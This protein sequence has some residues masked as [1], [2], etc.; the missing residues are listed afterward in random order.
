MDMI[1][2]TSGNVRRGRRIMAGEGMVTPRQP[3]AVE[4]D[5][6]VE[7]LMPG[8]DRLTVEH[9]LVRRQPEKFDLC[10]KRDRATRMRLREY[11]ER[12]LR[13]I[14]RELGERP[15]DTASCLR[16]PTSAANN[17]GLGVSR[18]RPKSWEL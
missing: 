7:T 2:T 4:E 11:H 5:G 3:M 16:L 10:W 8:R 15:T 13:H 14:E 9:P 17:Y 6:K 12:A 1:E 18:D